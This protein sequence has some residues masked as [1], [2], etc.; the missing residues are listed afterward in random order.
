[1]LRTDPCRLRKRLLGY[2]DV[3]WEVF[4]AASVILSVPSFCRVAITRRA[5][6]S[7]LDLD[8]RSFFPEEISQH[9]F[10]TGEIQ[11]LKYL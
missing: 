8:F 11:M 1:M 3:I 9:P 10:I 4:L 7:S 6:G 2:S 5:D